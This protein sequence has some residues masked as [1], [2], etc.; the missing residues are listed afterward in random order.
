MERLKNGWELAKDGLRFAINFLSSNARI[1]D[2]SLLS[3]PVFIIPIAYLAQQRGGAL[4]RQEERDL[5]YW[6]YVANARGRYS[7]GSA[8]QILDSDLAT[9]RKGTPTDLIELVRQQFGRLDLEPTDFVGRSSQS[10]LFS[11]VFLALKARGA[12]DWRS[13]LEISLTHQ[14]KLHYIQYHHIFPKA[15]L[16][17]LYETPEINEIA[18]MAFISGETNRKLGSKSPTEYLPRIIEERGEEALESQ[19]VPLDSALWPI[20]KYRDFL[21]VRRRRLVEVVNE[22]IGS[23]REGK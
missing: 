15:K 2:E 10:P 19:C 23:A 22:F 17:G 8:E 20:D 18:N 6:L 13:G 9:I 1:E 11:L 12:R 7:R 3:S 5:L 16:K 14:G 4:K 21:D